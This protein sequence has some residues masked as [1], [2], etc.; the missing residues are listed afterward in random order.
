MA[1]RWRWAGFT[2]SLCPALVVAASITAPITDRPGQ[3]RPGL[4]TATLPVAARTE[5][6]ILPE[7]DL[8]RPGAIRPQLDERL[9][10]A[11]DDDTLDQAFVVNPESLAAGL[12]LPAAARPGAIRPGDNTR[13]TPQPPPGKLFEVPPVVDRPLEIDDGEKVA[14]SSFVV[15]GAQD[16]PEHAI[17]VSAIQA[18]ADSHLSAHADGFTVGRL[19]EVADEVTKYYREHGL[20]LAQAFVP[21]QAVDNGVVRIQVLEGLLGQVLTEGNEMYRADV[22]TLPFRSLLGQ[23][24]TKEAMETALLTVS[25]LPGQS[26]FG[27]FQPGVQVGTADMVVKVQEEDRIALNLRADNHGIS[28]TG[29]NR[30]LGQLEFNNPIG[31]GDKLTGTVQHTEVPD[32]TFFYAVDYEIPVTGLYDSKFAL[33]INRNQFDVGGEFRDAE[34]SSDIRT[35]YAMLSRDFIR[36]RTMNLDAGLRLSKKRSGT[37]ASGRRVNLDSLAVLALEMNFDAVDARFA[38]LNAGYLEISH[39]FNDVLGAMGK[40]PAFVP[41]TRQGGTG[42]IAEGEFDKVLLNLSRFQSLSILWDKLENHSLLFAFEIM[43]SPDLLVPL[44]QYNIGGPT[45]VRGYRPTEG[46]FDRAVFGSVEWIINAPFIADQ[47]AFGNRT[48]GELMQLSVFY[49]VGSG[50]LNSAL[51]SERESENFNSVGFALSFNNPNVFSTKI[52]IAAPVGEPVPENG[53][54]PQYW[55]DLNFFF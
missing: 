47:P 32:N 44:E 5:A 13:L 53:K 21:V 1:V 19:Q 11:R 54:D 41:P 29:Q 46:L 22:L 48:W 35:Y 52:T 25:D 39:G 49:D 9:D 12:D 4:M 30:Y 3:V 36:S 15:E 14:V 37:K 43:W 24:V 17:E 55:V 16:R 28:E 8:A 38:G 26:S 2:A 27:V 18:I 33:G 51:P 50:K 42:N 7:S 31:Q 45:N 6:P 40:T 23:P 34:I 10:L 20:I